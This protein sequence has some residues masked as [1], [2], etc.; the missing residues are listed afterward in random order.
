MDNKSLHQS[1][2]RGNQ[3]SEP[4]A[5]LTLASLKCYFFFEALYCLAY[6]CLTEFTCPFRSSSAKKNILFWLHEYDHHFI[7]QITPT[8]LISLV[9]IQS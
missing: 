7:L 1:P 8:E 9:L 6:H 4:E 2:K 3:Q 5:T